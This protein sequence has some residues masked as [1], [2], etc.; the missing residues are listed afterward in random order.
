M[1]PT[2]SAPSPNEQRPKVT[3][4]GAGPAGCL[5]AI[6]LSD[7]GCSIDVYDYRLDPRTAKGAS[8]AQRSINLALST[9]GLTALKRAGVLDSVLEQSIPMHGRCIHPIDG[10]LQFH[11]YGQSHQFLLSISRRLLCNI[12]LDKCDKSGLVRLHFGHKCVHADLHKRCVTFERLDSA[13]EN[14]RP[15]ISV[16]S[17][18]IV[19]ADGSF[20][21]VRAAM[22]RE[23]RFDY[24]Q[25]YISAAYKELTMFNTVL[26]AEPVFPSNY[27]HI[28]PRHRFMLI[29]LPNNTTSFTCTLFMDKS[30]MDELSSPSKVESFFKTNFPDAV[31]LMPSLAQD[32]FQNPTP[33][34]VTI[35]CQPFN[36]DG[37]AILIGDA[38][39]A[40]VPFYGQGCNAA[41]EDCRLLAEAI[42]KHQWHDMPQVLSHYA[43][44]RKPNA[45]TIADLAIEHY[46]DMSS[47]SAKPL[48]VLRRR[49]EI[50]ANR[51][52]PRTFL[53]LYSMVSFSNIPYREAL[54]RARWQNRR[55][56]QVMVVTGIGVVVASVLFVG[57]G[58]WGRTTR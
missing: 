30:D 49:L 28:W 21:R 40:I 16:S 51:F 24:S 14:Q 54:V 5:L 36:H 46:E 58:I 43:S 33:S 2:H 18:L 45:D 6:L 11:P 34:L 22:A 10:R 25:S 26:S 1:A 31:G 57:R 4:V 39:H 12:L 27:L 47:K 44:T 3:I 23:D 56:E 9:R 13:A 15:H 48:A 17:D 37:N 8:G 52:F 35:R 38:A 50:W 42:E 55:I 7:T 32:Y 41:F 29:A 20:S 53:P 19:G